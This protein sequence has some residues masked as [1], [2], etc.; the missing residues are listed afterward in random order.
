MILTASRLQPNFLQSSSMQDQ[1]RASPIVRYRM[2]PTSH[3]Q[4]S[5]YPPPVSLHA[6]APRMCATIL[7]PPPNF[8]SC[9]VADAIQARHTF[10]HVVATSG[11]IRLF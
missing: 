1:R 2:P 7:T 8:F 11:A 4:H 6:L 9:Q 3:S 5:T 10:K